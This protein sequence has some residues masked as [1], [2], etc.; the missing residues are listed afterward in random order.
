M[1]LSKLSDH[2]LQIAVDIQKKYNID[3]EFVPYALQ[4]REASIR[5]NLNP[6]FVLQV[7]KQ[8]LTTKLD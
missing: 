1:D 5:H 7:K 2:E 6:D 3:S 8:L 4:V